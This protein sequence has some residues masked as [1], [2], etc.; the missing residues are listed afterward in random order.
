MP[1]PSLE[2]SV[3]E[4]ETQGSVVKQAMTGQMLV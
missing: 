4:G 1:H 2:R 3:R